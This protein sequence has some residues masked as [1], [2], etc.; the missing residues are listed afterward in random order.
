MRV[1]HDRSM[2]TSDVCGKGHE[3]LNIKGLL[4]CVWK[5]LNI[6]GISCLSMEG[7]GISRTQLW[8]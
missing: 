3:F 8:D 4:V 5:V 2:V 7:S 6:K 1:I